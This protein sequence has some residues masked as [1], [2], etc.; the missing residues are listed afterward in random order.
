MQ[1][2]DF[3]VAASVGWIMV[4]M[5]LLR[6]NF[7]RVLQIIISVLLWCDE[8]LIVALL[9]KGNCAMQIADFVLLHNKAEEALAKFDRLVVNF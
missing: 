1:I 5:D 6:W 3:A 8:F 4:R 7:A 2:A 9:C